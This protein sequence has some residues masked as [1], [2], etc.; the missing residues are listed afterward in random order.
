MVRKQ[1]LSGL[2][3]G[4]EA[5]EG[6]VDIREKQLEKAIMSK[7][8]EIMEFAGVTIRVRDIFDTATEHNDKPSTQFRAQRAL[9]DELMQH[10]DCLPSYERY[11]EWLADRVICFSP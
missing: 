7:F 6:I 1:L 11:L 9:M 5:K 3:G 10:F 2:V 4:S 8:D